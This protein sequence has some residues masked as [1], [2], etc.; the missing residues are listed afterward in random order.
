MVKNMIVSITTIETL[1]IVNQTT[2]LVNY[3]INKYILSIK[4]N[5]NLIKNLKYNCN[6]II[7]NKFM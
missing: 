6:G 7:N 2:S 5:L 3:I 1:M 4:K